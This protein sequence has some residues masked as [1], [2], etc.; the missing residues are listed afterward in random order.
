MKRRTFLKTCVA[1]AALTRVSWAARPVTP[2]VIL[3]LR[4]GWDALSVLI[5]REGPDRKLYELVRPTLKI[6]PPKELG[7]GRGLNPA[8]EPLRTLPLAVVQATGTSQETRSH[9]QACQQLDSRGLKAYLRDSPAVALG[10]P[11]SGLQGT[12]TLTL[13]SLDDLAL[14]P[15]DRLHLA[16]TYTRD[17][18][19]DR[20]TREALRA[21]EPFQRKSRP[22]SRY[23]ETDLGESLA[24]AARILKLDVGVKVVTVERDGWDTHEDQAGPLAELLTELRDAVLAFAKDMGS[25]P[26]VLLIQSE[27]GRRI[28]ENGSGGTD[29]G[30]GGVTLLTGP[31]VRPGLY[32]EW[33]GLNQEDLP[34]RTDQHRVLANV[35][36][37][38]GAKG[39]FPPSGL[40]LFKDGI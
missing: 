40:R 21:A 4:G 31:T 39:I 32:G 30:R 33:P 12:R 13:Y 1:A 37:H 18:W 2:L 5:P 23:P 20:A 3:S 7:E 17:T 16:T 26:Y 29:H 27:F 10:A 25:R 28:A 35:L 38:L 24:E 22:T 6:K 19:L 34:V 8:L 14:E 11:Y 9:F 36:E 15:E